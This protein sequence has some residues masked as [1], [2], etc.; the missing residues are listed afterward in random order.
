MS[1]TPVAAPEWPLPRGLIILLGAGAAVLAISGLRAGSDLIGPIFLALVL[2]VAIHPLRG[3]LHKHGWPPW[4]STL[5]GI[6]V[7]YVVLIAIVLALLY[8]VAKFATLLPRYQANLEELV[9]SVTGLLS[10]AGVGQDQIA[11]ISGSFDPRK[12]VSLVGGLLSGL[13][14]TVSGLF[15][16]FVL[17]LFLGIDAGKFPAKLTAQRPQRGAVVTALESFAQGTRRYLVVVTIF[18]LI[19]A[20]LDTG[21]LL[22]T[23]IPDPLLWGLLAFITNFI[24]NIGFVVG[25]VPPAVLGLFE[26]GPGLMLLVIVVY[27]VLNAIIQSVIQPR[28]VG[29]AVGLSGTISFVSLVFWAWVLGAIGA[30]FAVPLTLL[31]KALLIDVDRHSVWLGPLLDGGPDSSVRAEP[32]SED[33]RT[34]SPR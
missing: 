32:R 31:V 14:G 27:S 25:L 7:A 5:L 15:F 28:V 16:L 21:F 4:A 30:L 10:K 26:G 34:P 8:T 24:P 11:S 12:L 29:D 20:V 3:Y 1:K 33:P 2:T 18:G 13:L 19:V 17:L 22:F 6:L 9:S 23:P